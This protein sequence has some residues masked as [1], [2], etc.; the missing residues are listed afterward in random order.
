MKSLLIAITFTLLP[1]H[2]PAADN[3]NYIVS[4]KKQKI[5]LPEKQE[6]SYN[7]LSSALF[8]IQALE[9]VAIYRDLPAIKRK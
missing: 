4:S 1:N 6:L 3:D 5:Q 9:K 7:A 2:L 8:P